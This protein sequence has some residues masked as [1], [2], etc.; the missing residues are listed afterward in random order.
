MLSVAKTNE[1]RFPIRINSVLGAYREY[2]YIVYDIIEEDSPDIVQEGK[3]KFVHC[4]RWIQRQGAEV[5]LLNETQH[6]CTIKRSFIR[7]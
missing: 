6:F 1:R 2:N 3:L 5:C 4:F 7:P